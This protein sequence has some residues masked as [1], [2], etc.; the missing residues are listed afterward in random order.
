M[1]GVEISFKQDFKISQTTKG[2]KFSKPIEYEDSYVF[3]IISISD[4]P[5]DP[6]SWNIHGVLIAFC[7]LTQKHIR[8]LI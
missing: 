4:A 6:E 3:F 1:I 5:D 8:T 7:C 2:S